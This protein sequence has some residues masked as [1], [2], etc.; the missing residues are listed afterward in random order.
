MRRQNGVTS[1]DL[2]KWKNYLARGIEPVEQ[3][4]KAA[5]EWLPAGKMAFYY[6][7]KAPVIIEDEPFARTFINIWLGKRLQSQNCG[8]HFLVKINDMLETPTTF[9]LFFRNLH[10]QNL[11]L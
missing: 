5:V 2:V 3:G 11:N 10:T 4:A 8:R 7:T 6:N 9:L 1:E